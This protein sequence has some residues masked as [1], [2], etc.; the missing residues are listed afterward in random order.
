[1]HNSQHAYKLFRPLFLTV[2]ISNIIWPEF[3]MAQTREFTYSATISGPSS[4]ALS[5][6]L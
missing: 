2:A 3:T 6:A 5:D 4:V 1:M